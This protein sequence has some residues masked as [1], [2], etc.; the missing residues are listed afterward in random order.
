MV[1][2]NFNVRFH[3]VKDL[4]SEMLIFL[5]SYMPIIKTTTNRN[6]LIII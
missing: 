6:N 2:L 3:N 1:I 5:Q 4:K